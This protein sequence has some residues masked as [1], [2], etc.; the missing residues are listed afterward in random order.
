MRRKAAL[1]SAEF[2]E[3]SEA[4][5]S[6]IWKHG[7]GECNVARQTLFAGAGQQSQ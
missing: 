6:L 3:I 1:I 7:S 5:R 2:A 4:L